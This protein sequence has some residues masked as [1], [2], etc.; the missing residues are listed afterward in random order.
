MIGT[1]GGAAV[2]A[3]RSTFDDIKSHWAENE[4]EKMTTLGYLKGSDG[5]F[6]PDESITRAEFVT[7]MVRIL[8][9]KTD[10]SETGFTDVS[11][12][13]WFA[14]YISSAVSQKIVKGYDDGSFKPNNPITREEI[15]S[16]LSTVLD[17]ELSEKDTEKLLEKFNDKV[18]P[19]AET[20][21]AKSVEAG[22]LNGFPD[23]TFKGSTNATRAQSAVMLLRFLSN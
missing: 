6:R 22:L 18:S 1:N 2:Q 5:N 15:S 4:V 17:L 21:V 13:D 16:L 7:L 14:P 19:W 9:L 12:D 3:N 20:Y 11:S 23:G 10:K 8:G